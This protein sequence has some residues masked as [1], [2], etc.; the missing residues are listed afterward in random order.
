LASPAVV[1]VGDFSDVNPQLNERHVMAS[2][3]AR[4]LISAIVGALLAAT[5]ASHAAAAPSWN[6]SVGA[7]GDNNGA[8][9][10]DADIGWSPTDRF[11]VS[12]S[13]GHAKGSD[14][15][16]N[17]SSTTLFAGA[18]WQIAKLFGVGLAY[19]SWDDSNAYEKRTAHGTVYIGNERARVGLL[20]QSVTSTTT[21]Q[22]AL[23]RREVTIDFDGKGYGAELE[24]NGE[25]AGFYAS[26]VS[27]DYDDNV[28]RLLT[29][30]ANPN[31]SQ[32]PRLEALA[33]SGLTAAAALLDYSA[34]VGA[35]FYVRD[36]RIGVSYSLLRDLVSDSDSKSLRG[37]FE[38]PFADH[39]AAR[40]TAGVNDSDI[41]DSAVLGGVRILYRSN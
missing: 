16:G 18:D 21:A 29:F 28:N 7:E 36:S 41:E 38:W 13:A 33:G 35:N 2:R 4:P 6:A 30:L 32:R 40:L 12:F 22:L 19:D 10:G 23:L 34:N 15:S 11:G 20:A 17:F 39:W 3:F 14:E 31:L 1:A 5:Y 24:L 37:E 26:Y 9:V 8:S 25:R 27:Y